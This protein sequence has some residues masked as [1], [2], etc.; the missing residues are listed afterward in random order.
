MPLFDE[1]GSPLTWGSDPTAYPDSPH[2]SAE[3]TPGPGPGVLTTVYDSTGEVEVIY[4]FFASGVPTLEGFDALRVRPKVR[5]EIRRMGVA[6]IRWSQPVPVPSSDERDIIIHQR[7]YP[8]RFDSASAEAG[9]WTSELRGRAVASNIAVAT[10]QVAA[11]PLPA[12]VWQEYYRVKAAIR[13]HVRHR[14]GHRPRRSGSI[15]S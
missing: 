8:P 1:A 2:P 9:R 11:L 3:G 13:S 15:P 4:H 12:G 10:Y 5:E 7:Y 6:A 14:G